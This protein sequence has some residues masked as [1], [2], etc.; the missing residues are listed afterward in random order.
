MKVQLSL[1]GVKNRSGYK[2]SP[3]KISTFSVSHVL[4]VSAAIRY[5]LL[6]VSCIR[7]TAF[8]NSNTVNSLNTVQKVTTGWPFV[9]STVNTLGHLMWFCLSRSSFL[10]FVITALFPSLSSPPSPSL[11]S[12]FSLTFTH[13]QQSYWPWFLLICIRHFSFF[14]IW[15]WGTFPSLRE[16]T[17]ISLCVFSKGLGYEMHIKYP[18][19]PHYPTDKITMIMRQKF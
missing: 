10:V 9:K 3:G 6:K 8:G 16:F 1:N 2:E 4:K 5:L 7:D 17:V 15:R 18:L 13:S 11:P 12:S 14:G 19:I